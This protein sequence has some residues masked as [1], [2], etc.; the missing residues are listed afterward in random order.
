MFRLWV[1]Y[2][3]VHFSSGSTVLSGVDHSILP[4]ATSCPIALAVK[5]LVIDAIPYLVSESGASDFSM[6][7][8]PKLAVWIVLPPCWTPSDRP[9]APVIVHISL[10]MLSSAL[11]RSTI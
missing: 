2:S 6:S 9:G 1:M 5:T 11:S 4:S 3:S 8:K 7:R 10:M